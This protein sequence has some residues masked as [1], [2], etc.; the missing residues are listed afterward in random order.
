VFPRFQPGKKRIF[1]GMGNQHVASGF[2]PVRLQIR[3]DAATGIYE[4]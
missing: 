1:P 3:I 4:N 2:M